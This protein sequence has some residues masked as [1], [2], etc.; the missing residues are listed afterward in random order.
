MIVLVS[1]VQQCEIVSQC[2]AKWN[3]YIHIYL[4][5]IY[6]LFFRYFSHEG[7]HRILSIKFTVL[8]CRSLFVIYSNCL[9]QFQSPNLSLLLPFPLVIINKFVFYIFLDS[10]RK[11]YHSL[12]VWLTSLSMTISRSIRVATNDIILFFF[13]AE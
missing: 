5:N 7:Y 6:P 8:Y 10:T 2:T 12:S 3:I 9:C 4:Y 1:G 11:W 13:M